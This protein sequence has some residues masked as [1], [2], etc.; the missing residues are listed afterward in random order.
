MN[1]QK[2]TLHKHRHP[3][4]ERRAETVQGEQ[5][6]KEQEQVLEIKNIIIM[7]K[8]LWRGFKI[9]AKKIYK[10]SDKERSNRG[11]KREKSTKSVSRA[12]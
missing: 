5:T 6:I 8:V 9:K 4:R 1:K 7:I 2:K 12:N 10:Q 3:F 11:E